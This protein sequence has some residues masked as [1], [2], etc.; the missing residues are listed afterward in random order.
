MVLRLPRQHLSPCIMQ[1]HPRRKL[2]THHKSRSKSK[3][4]IANRKPNP[5]HL[6]WLRTNIIK[7]GIRKNKTGNI[8]KFLC[9]D[10]HKY[11]TFN[12]GFERMKHN[13]QAITSAMQLYF[14]GESL[15]NTMRSLQLL[16]VEVSYRT[17]LNWI[18]K[19]T[20]L[21][22]QYTEQITPNVG[23]TWRA[24]E[25]YIKIKGDMKYLFAMMDDETRFWIAQEVADTKDQHDTMML[26]SRASDLMGK[27]PKD[28]RN[29]WIESLR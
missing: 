8:Q 15:R 27:Q 28:P 11:M 14:S 17:I 20:R 21:M 12:I 24:D 7:K 1:T 13:P 10:C 19:Y 22:Q 3:N 29:R 2:F 4:N 9:Q 5:M 16:G 25:I 26:F 23:D 18:R 6:L